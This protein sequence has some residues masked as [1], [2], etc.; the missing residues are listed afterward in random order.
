MLFTD[1]Q[2]SCVVGGILQAVVLVAGLS[3]LVTFFPFILLILLFVLLFGT[4][5]HTVFYHYRNRPEKT[6]FDPAGGNH[7]FEKTQN[8]NCCDM[9]QEVIHAETIDGDTENA[10]QLPAATEEKRYQ[11]PGKQS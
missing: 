4:R 10:E 7:V 3:L 11:N 1:R 2:A 6:D 8:R 5:K 9:E